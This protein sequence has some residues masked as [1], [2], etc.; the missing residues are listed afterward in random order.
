MLLWKL[1]SFSVRQKGDARV[2]LSLSYRSQDAMG[3]DNI[4]WLQTTDSL[5]YHCADTRQGGVALR[6]LFGELKNTRSSSKTRQR[7]GTEREASR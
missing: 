6:G 5:Y 2:R 4:E 1:P 7:G 3:L